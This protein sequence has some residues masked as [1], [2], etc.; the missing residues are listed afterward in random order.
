M[1]TWPSLALATLLGV[2]FLGAI[3]LPGLDPTVLLVISDGAQLLAATAAAVGCLAAAR[4]SSAHRRSA[5]RWLAAGCAS[6]A[7]GQLVWS[8]YEVYLGREAP[9]PSLADVG[10]LFFPALAGVG[11]VR[12]LGTQHDQLV[13]RSRDVLD[14][15]ILAGSLLVVSWVTTLGSV[16]EAGAGSWL[17]FALSLAYP[18]GDLVLATLV[19]LALVRASRAERST[20]VALALG[21]GALAVADSAY[22]FLVGAGSYS[23][24]ELITGGWVLG[25]AWVAAAGFG[26]A[27]R[28]GSGEVVVSERRRSLLQ[29]LLPY[30][31]LLVA[32]A[33]LGASRVTGASDASSGLVLALVLIAVVVARQLLELLESRRLLAA[34]AQ[35]RD[36]LQRQATHDALTG[37]ANRSLFG[38]RLDQALRRRDTGVAVL[39]CDLDDLKAVNDSHGHD[40]GDAL[41]A[42]VAARLLAGVRGADTVARLSG[43]EF[44]V[45]LPEAHDADL[46][47][48]R[49]VGEVAVPLI[50][51]GRRLDPSISIGVARCDPATDPDLDP[52][53]R[54]S[55]LLQRA[56]RAMYAA[57]LAGKG[58][59]VAAPRTSAPDRVDAAR[60]VSGRG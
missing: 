45:L 25:F 29:L 49:L 34:L 42:E 15:A 14:G 17:P 5:W 33:S 58:Q 36:A 51:Q 20:L 57:K 30:A 31:A 41:L 37:L 55:A 11:L 43:D 13:A 47:A 60:A 50:V 22:V 21:L 46:V 24:A 10:F 1:R 19:L 52:A 48:A 27:P 38:E 23:S 18:L 39:F 53:T 26:A 59:V 40:V 35:A 32:V 44:A 56:D 28:A 8:V 4:G 54:A 2:A 7:A 3:R 16:L 12:W 6:W 9:F